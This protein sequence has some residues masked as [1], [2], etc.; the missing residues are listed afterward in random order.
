M[1]LF[2]FKIIYALAAKKIPT[3]HLTSGICLIAH[4]KEG[5]DRTKKSSASSQKQYPYGLEEFAHIF[6][7]LTTPTYV[8]FEWKKNQ[9]LIAH[10]KEGVDGTKKSS[11]RSQKKSTPSF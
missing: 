3:F 2:S 7:K 1:F 11:A 9:S 6:G 4:Q 5:I 8:M 10:Q